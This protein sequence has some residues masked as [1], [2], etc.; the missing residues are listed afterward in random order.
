MT[1]SAAAAGPLLL[2]L[3]PVLA[4]EESTLPVTPE[5]E[6]RFTNL[7]IDKLNSEPDPDRNL[8]PG[9]VSYD[10]SASY[11]LSQGWEDEDLDA[12][13]LI[14]SYSDG[15]FVRREVIEVQGVSADQGTISFDG[16]FTLPNC[17]GI[18]EVL[19]YVDLSLAS[20]PNVVADSDAYFVDV[21]GTSSVPC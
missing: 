6:P 19:V 20:D 9:P 5:G 17:G 3:L 10:V 11:Q 21:V 15:A 7:V 18:D 14:E 4:C 13:L 12:F 16:S 8:D 2:L 1:R